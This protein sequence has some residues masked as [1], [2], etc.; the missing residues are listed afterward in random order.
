MPPGRVEPGLTGRLLSRA[1]TPCRATCNKVDPY[2]RPLYDAPPLL[3]AEKTMLL[4]KGVI[5]VAPWPMWGRRWRCLCIL[6]EAQNTR[7]RCMVLPR[8][9]ERSDGRDRRHHP[10]GSSAP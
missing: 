4:E 2:L 8:L 7:L 1:P 10:G 6:D 9:G 5:E 3:G